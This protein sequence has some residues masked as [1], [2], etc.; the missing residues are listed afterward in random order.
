MPEVRSDI[1]LDF[2]KERSPFAHQRKVPLDDDS[3]QFCI[4]STGPTLQTCLTTNRRA[5]DWDK[6]PTVPI[7]LLLGD[8]EDTPCAHS[9]FAYVG[10]CF[11]ATRDHCAHQIARLEPLHPL[12]FLW[13]ATREPE[14]ID[15]AHLPAAMPRRHDRSGITP[16]R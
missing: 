9:D 3:E 10:T 4:G 5:S 14:L 7:Y 16:L 15:V 12:G 13:L 11:G 1:Q 2:Y 6:H 8:V